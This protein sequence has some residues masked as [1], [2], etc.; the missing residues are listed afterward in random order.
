MYF[1][2]SALY[3]GAR[4]HLKQLAVYLN[5]QFKEQR[6]RESNDKYLHKMFARLAY[7]RGFPCGLTFLSMRCF[8][9]HPTCIRLASILNCI[10]PVFGGAQNKRECSSFTNVSD[11]ESHNLLHDQANQH[12]MRQQRGGVG[13]GGMLRVIHSHAVGS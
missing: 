8:S 9:L 7:V 2:R 12:P 6:T 4:V 3:K 1:V 5:N 13:G 10:E 11:N